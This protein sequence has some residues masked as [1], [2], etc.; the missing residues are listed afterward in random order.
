[1]TEKTPIEP[2]Q[3]QAG[4]LIR[5]EWPEGRNRGGQDTVKAVEYVAA[6][7][8]D[9]GYF[10][11]DDMPDG[12]YLIERPERPESPVPTQPT[13]GVL[14]LKNGSTLFG[15]W[16]TYDYSLRDGVGRAVLQREREIPVAE[17]VGFLPMDE[18]ALVAH[19]DELDAIDAA[20]EDDQ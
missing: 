6:R 2:D 7:H 15:V 20:R 16:A 19:L 3:I 5:A 8:G 18:A 17:V 13:P 14:A 9:A 10:D 12:L 1:M 4:D 11:P